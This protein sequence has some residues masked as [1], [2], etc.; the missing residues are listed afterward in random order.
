MGSLRQKTAIAV[1]VVLSGFLAGTLIPELFRMGTGAYAGLLSL[2][3]LEKYKSIAVSSEK[4]FPY[5]V[6]VRLKTLLFLWMSCYTS[7]GLL[8]HLGYAWWLASSAGLILSLFVLRDG[9]SGVLLFFCCIFP[10]WILYASM[11]KQELLFLA[12]RNY[13]G[14]QLQQGLAVSSRRD[15]IAGL[16]RMTALCVVGCAVEAFFGIWTLKIFLQLFT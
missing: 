16:A 15:E 1:F 5:I 12:R 13:R 14:L 10:Q 11:W 9:Y 8:F 6:S 2:Y 7:A 3:S 4:I